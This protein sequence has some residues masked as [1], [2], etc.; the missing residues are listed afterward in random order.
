MSLSLQAD[1]LGL[2]QEG[3]WLAAHPE[4]TKLI[5]FHRVSESEQ[6]LH[7]RCTRVHKS[8]ML[9][10]T[11]VL[12]QHTTQAWRWRQTPKS[13]RQLACRRPQT[14][15]GKFRLHHLV[16]AKALKHWPHRRLTALRGLSALVQCLSDANGHA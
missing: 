16:H 9:W 5:P 10:P 15:R 13:L 6:L 1:P 8:N 4:E 7:T 3:L 14:L 12:R 11:E 2:V